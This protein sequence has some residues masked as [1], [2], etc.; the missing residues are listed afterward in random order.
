MPY[1][2]PYTLSM[3]EAFGVADRVHFEEPLE[4]LRPELARADAFLMSSRID[5]YPCVVLEAMAMGT[6]V[7]LFDKATGST[8]FIEA[9][10]GGEVVPYLATKA[11]AEIL[12]NWI[13]NPE[14]A[15]KMGE[16]ARKAVRAHATFA[17]YAATVYTRTHMPS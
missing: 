1:A 15:A 5:P 13:H 17:P 2:L 11:A 3:A 9:H 4:D 14:I 8:D 10:G 12:S 6:P 7:V 16:A